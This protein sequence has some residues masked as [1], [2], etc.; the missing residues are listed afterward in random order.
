MTTS[1][2]INVRLSSHT[3]KSCF[4][5][6]YLL[7]HV[8]WY[9]I[10]FLQLVDISYG[11]TAALEQD[12]DLVSIILRALLMTITSL[13]TTTH[14]LLY[15]PGITMPSGSLQ[16]VWNRAIAS[17]TTCVY[18]YIRVYQLW[19]MPVF[20]RPMFVYPL[21]K[22]HPS[23]PFIP[24][25]QQVYREGPDLWSISPESV[26][27]SIQ[28]SVLTLLLIL[29]LIVTRIDDSIFEKNWSCST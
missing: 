23:E 12:H 27:Y 19:S 21:P 17:T 24:S 18:P 6:V 9:Y 4:R 28:L 20:W 26:S 8:S 2:Q 16:A 13:H 15:S 7:A 25:D 3:I 11:V 10:S 5:I 1:N 22:P 14:P 29:D